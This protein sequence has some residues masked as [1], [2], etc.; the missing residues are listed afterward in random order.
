MRAEVYAA[1]KSLAERWSPELIKFSVNAG[2][3]TP[4]CLCKNAEGA[5]FPFQVKAL[6]DGVE[7]TIHALEVD[8]AH[9]GPGAAAHLDE[10]ALNNIGGAQLL[11]PMPR[12]AEE[13]QQLR[14]SLHPLDI[15][16]AVHA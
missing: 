14:V 12:E 3:V 10:A 8:K 16:E 9:H 5:G 1:A 6:E 2:L 11:P 15:H 4:S 7:D 13:R